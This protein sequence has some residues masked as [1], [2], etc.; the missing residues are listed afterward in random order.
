MLSPKQLTLNLRDHL[1]DNEASWADKE[2]RWGGADPRPKLGIEG[3]KAPS[4]AWQGRGLEA[5][6]ARHPPTWRAQR[7]P[8]GRA[9]GLHDLPRLRGA[10]PGH[11]QLRRQDRRHAPKPRLGEG[12]VPPRARKPFKAMEVNG[13]PWNLARM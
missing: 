12:R 13:N 6:R 9:L 10:V 2:M 4:S 5:P 3:D 1:Y 7:R 8:P 11:D